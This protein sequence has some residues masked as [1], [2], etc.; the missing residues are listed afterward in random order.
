[1]IEHEISTMTLKNTHMVQE[2]K[3]EGDY[4]LMGEGGQPDVE[5]K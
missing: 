4:R 2:H 1:M 3:Q 5:E